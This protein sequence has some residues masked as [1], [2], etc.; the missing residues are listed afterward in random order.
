MDGM[1]Q[2]MSRAGRKLK[3][4]GNRKKV[5][6]WEVKWKEQSCSET[7]L[8]LK[9]WENCKLRWDEVWNEKIEKLIVCESGK[10]SRNWKIESM[11]T[12]KKKMGKYQE[13]WN[14]GK[15]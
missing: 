15:Y 3:N 10:E 12:W 4:G 1:L 13:N 9:I 14:L 11:E 7:E 8:D 6:S 5:L 2:S